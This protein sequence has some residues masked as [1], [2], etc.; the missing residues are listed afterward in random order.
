MRNIYVLV[1]ICLLLPNCSSR[2]N[3]V[4]ELIIHGVILLNAAAEALRTSETDAEAY[5]VL[6]RLAIE[7]LALKRQRHKLKKKYTALG[8]ETRLV[9]QRAPIAMQKLK[10]AIFDFMA[11]SKV[12]RA[13]LKQKEFVQRY[14]LLVDIVKN[15]ETE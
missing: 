15:F 7:L 3:D 5:A 2:D 12:N 13:R 9:W 10:L 1:L 8:P 4:K 6:D 14:K 11:A